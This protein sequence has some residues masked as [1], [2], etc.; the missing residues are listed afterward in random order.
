MVISREN[1]FARKKADFETNINV[2]IYHT[3]EE[4]LSVAVFSAVNKGTR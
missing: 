2:H 3:L 4:N 1:M